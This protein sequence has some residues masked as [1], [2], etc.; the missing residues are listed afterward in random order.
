[1]GVGLVLWVVIHWYHEKWECPYCGRRPHRDDCYLK[2]TGM[3][4]D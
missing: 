2:G 4:G 1:M 3:W